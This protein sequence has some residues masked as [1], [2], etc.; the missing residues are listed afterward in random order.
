MRTGLSS[1]S[2]PAAH[3]SLSSWQAWADAMFDAV[4]MVDAHSMRVIAANRAAS[5]LMAMAP[6]EFIAKEAI[7]LAGTPEDLCF[8]GEAAQG[9]NSGIESD[10]QVISADGKVH[11]VARRV[12]KVLAPGGAPAFVV[13]LRDRT[14][15]AAAE[16]SLEVVLGDLRATL[17]SM[18]DG[19]LV[20]DLSGRIRNFNQRF[21]ALWQLPLE[22]S[23][24]HDDDAVLDW[25]RQSVAEPAAYMRRLAEFDE[26]A[27]LQ[28]N[29]HVLLRSGAVLE[30][31]T[32]PQC[33]NGSPIG[34]IQIFRDVTSE[35]ENARCAELLLFNDPLTNLPN[36]R[37]LT[38]RVEAALA[39]CT[40][41]GTPFS[42]LVLNLDRFNHINDT[43]GRAF[44][45]RVLQ[46]IAMR[47]RS[48]VRQVDT[49]ARLGG[50]EF[51]LLANQSD[52]AGA[53]AAARRVMDA[54][55]QPFT[56]SGMH[57]TVTAS[58]GIASHPEAGRHV[59]DLLRSADLAMREAKLAG[60]A[61]YRFH[62]ARPDGD[63]HVARTRMHLDYAMRQALPNGRFRVAYQPQVDLATGLV[64]GAEA[65]LRWNDVERGEI[66]PG[67]FIPVAEES[68]FIIAL[69]DWVLK[70]SVEQAAAWVA[71]GRA[72]T[73]SVNVSALQFRQPG[74]VDGVAA[75]LAHAKLEPHWLEL[76]L[77]E[78]ILVQDAPEAMLRLSALA[79]LGVKLAIDD[80]GTGY[81]SLSYLKR[82]P[83]GRLKID[84]SFVS[85][86]PDSESDVAIVHAIIQLGRALK[87]KT[88]A[89][90][91]ETE[92]QRR[93]LQSA[94][95]DDFQGFLYAPALDAAAF[96]VRTQ[97]LPERA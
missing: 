51:V 12:N 4:W 21:A 64:T 79:E 40:R 34:R 72:M 77:T 70:R 38:D 20:T 56:E 19:I 80:F 30:R 42:L 52:R 55:K 1:L 82:F 63:D 9:L 17:E 71:A 8:W 41:D 24:T 5:Q 61:T 46:E 68:G 87:L 36:R 28:A 35:L 85:G 83:I 29:D 33:S 39:R 97:A 27:L 81:S 73:I 84:R 58:I 65:L 23:A 45:D 43:L 6:A 26:V 95:C 25:M 69:G 60:R 76:E 92:A 86:L 18:R 13:V 22:L 37:L 53:E 93:F 78:S 94:G 90:G 48:C 62:Q 3:E 7:E 11:Q 10:T 66:S 88:V 31:T 49:L 96:N 14:A 44:G 89:E 32:L 59:D 54:L 67:E 50:D 2:L 75:A 15:Q 47:I 16:R 91:V 57:F 74:F